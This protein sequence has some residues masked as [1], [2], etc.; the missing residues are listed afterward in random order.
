MLD[1]EITETVLMD[2]SK[3]TVDAL[4]ELKSLGIHLSLDDFG[5][6]YSSLNY[7]QRLPIDTLKIDRSFI[8]KLASNGEQGKIIET[9]LL[10]G[11]NLGIEV[12]AEGDRDGRATDE[13]EDDQLRKGQGFFFS[14]PKEGRRRAITARCR[15]E[16]DGMSPSASYS[17]RQ[18]AKRLYGNDKPKSRAFSFPFTLHPNFSAM[19]FHKI[20]AQ[21][22]SQTCPLVFP[23]R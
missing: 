2:Q 21:C 16:E 9:I 13:I 4:L 23:I 8:N 5:T 22:E 20:P 7:L 18:A 10:F 3:S 15:A 14:R 1:L 17:P 11:G 6:G 12:V 19:E